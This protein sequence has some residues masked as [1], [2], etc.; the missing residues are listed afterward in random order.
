[1]IGLTFGFS[2]PFFIGESLEV[3]WFSTLGKNKA[4]SYTA[5]ILSLW[6]KVK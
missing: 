3:C 5:L 4:I 6:S 1:M 2:S